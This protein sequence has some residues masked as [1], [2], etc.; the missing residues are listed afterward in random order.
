[1]QTVMQIG[2][3]TPLVHSPPMDYK[4]LSLRY[5]RDV[6]EQTG[7][8]P[9]QLARMVGKS[10]TTFTR[11]LAA[12]DWR[13]SIRFDTLADLAERT[14]IP[15][16]P[17][18]IASRAEGRAFQPQVTLPVRYEV[19]AGA[20]LLRDELP[21]EPYG[22]EV[23]SSL[24]GYE[25]YPQWLERV[26]SDSM[27]RLFP[28]G[29]LLHVVDAVAMRYKPQHGDIVVVERERGGLVERT[30][31]QVEMTPSGVCLWPRSH[32]PRWQAPI[33]VTDGVR[34]GEDFD[35][36]IVG[37]VLRSFQRWEAS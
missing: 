31:K 5:L 3:H 22:Q 26:V 4:A 17:D 12:E 15:L 13:F 37:R 32:N 19:A 34:D 6:V 30:V 24:P 35:V 36:T 2:M 29:S 10:P 18:L 9:S 27:D 23:V 25:D 28:P 20:F 21:Q 33:M 7:K 1:M 8:T 11:P 14:G 16:P